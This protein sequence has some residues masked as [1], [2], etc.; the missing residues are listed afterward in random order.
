MLRELNEELGIQRAKVGCVADTKTFYLE[1]KQAWLMWLVYTV[2]ISDTKFTYGDGVTAATFLDV[3]T[4]ANSSDI[5]EKMVY[6]IASRN[7]AQL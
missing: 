3:A 6:E 4:L 2:N 5:F 1:N 7:A